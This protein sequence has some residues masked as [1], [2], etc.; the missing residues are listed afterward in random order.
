MIK[1]GLKGTKA[2]FDV[3]QTFP[4]GRLRECHAEKLVQARKALDLVLTAVLRHEAAKFR[5]R[6]QIHEL[7]ENGA[8]DI[9]SHPFSVR[10]NQKNSNQIIKDIMLE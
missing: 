8:A 7:G 9:H 2:N 5:Q 1:P 4:I 6:E 3:A 10:K